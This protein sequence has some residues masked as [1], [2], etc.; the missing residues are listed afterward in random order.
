MTDALT[1]RQLIGL[2]GAAAAGATAAGIAGCSSPGTT[3]PSGG[4]GTTFPNA[5]MT[6]AEHG[7]PYVTRPDLTPPDITI[8][9]RS[10]RA[11]SGY[12]FLNAPYSGP[13]HG[14]SMIID[15]R[16]QLVWFGPNTATEHRMNVDVQTYR[17]EKVLTWWEG[18]VVQGYGKGRLVIADSSYRIKHV[19]HAARGLMADLHEFVVTPQGTALITAYKRWP[20]DLSS[21]GGPSSGYM[22]SGV[23]QEID[24]QTGKL[25]FEWDSRNH[26]PLNDTY[27]KYEKGTGT[28]EKPFNYFHINSIAVDVDGNWLISSR[29]TWTV[30]KIDRHH[31]GRVLWRINGK[32]SDFTMEPRTHFYW[33][34]HVRPHGPGVL[35]VFDNGA[36]PAEEKHSRALVLAIDEKARRVR[37]TKAYVHPGQTLLAGAMGSAELMPNGNMFVGWGTCPNFSMFAHDGTLLLDGRMTKHDPSYRAFTHPWTGH[38]KERPAVAARHRSGHSVVYASWNGATEVAFWTVLAGRTRSSVHRIA[39]ARK[40]GFETV[41]PV[42][43]SGPYFAVQAHTAAGHVLAESPVVEI[44]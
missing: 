37:L 12:I 23:A 28:A 18:L 2:A 27:Q 4:T 44:R 30:Y 13:G 10:A 41:I 29:N 38:P 20:A 17:G 25:L 16:G 33:Q 35:T 32:H 8:T 21:V 11:G 5:P 24:I 1:R 9:H 6:S 15:Y 14:G 26:V 42:H 34:H 7:P 19:I 39:R 36:K 40:S 22:L 43:N 31:G 3:H